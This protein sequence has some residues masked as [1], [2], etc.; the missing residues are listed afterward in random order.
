MA[1]P[2][3]KG[4]VGC[5]S[6]VFTWRSNP[7]RH[8]RHQNLSF[9]PSSCGPVC[10]MGSQSSW[11][12]FIPLHR[13]SYS[14]R[15]YPIIYSQLRVRNQRLDIRLS[16]HLPSS[17]QKR[18]GFQQLEKGERGREGGKEGREGG[19]GEWKG[20]INILHFILAPL[21]PRLIPASFP[22]LPVSL[23]LN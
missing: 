6:K 1:F 14:T 20:E 5:H 4:V 12:G 13:G 10:Y 19:G 18:G 2:T 17:L 3:P 7:V 9:L 22:L 15:Y 8:H 23:T 21:A 11:L 16:N